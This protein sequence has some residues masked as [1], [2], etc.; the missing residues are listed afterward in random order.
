MP[1]L[2]ATLIIFLGTFVQATFGFGSALIAMPLLITQMGIITAS[3]LMALVCVLQNA[4]IVIFSWRKINWSAAWRFLVSSIVAIPFGLLLILYVPEIIV[5]WILGITL[6]F[7]GLYSLLP[8]R[9]P[10]LKDDRWAL[11][12]GFLGGIL[13]AAYNT[14]GPPVVVYG[15][16]RR[17]SPESFR[18][19]LNGYF[20]PIGMIIAIGHGLGG[21]WTVSIWSYFGVAVPAVLLATTAGSFL[22]RRIDPARFNRILYVLIILIGILMLVPR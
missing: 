14:N 15:A 16:M 10:E 9:L 13:G 3:P 6:I 22:N 5:K 19:T 20:L 2:T 18:A 4:I 1:I 17:W 21:L 8:V 11:L 7:Y 12:F